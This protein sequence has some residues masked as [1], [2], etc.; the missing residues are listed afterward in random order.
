NTKNTQGAMGAGSAA[1]GAATAA[2]CSWRQ[3]DVAPSVC[4]IT[5][6]MGASPM[7]HAARGAGAR[8]EALMPP[9]D[10]TAGAATAR[11]HQT[12]RILGSVK[13]SNSSRLVLENS[14]T[15]APSSPDW[16]QCHVFDG[17]VYC[18]PGRSSIS[19]RSV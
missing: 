19:R 16:N 4:L 18:S 8:G 15:I 14:L 7:H 10:A 9:R 11:T 2:N 1:A 3:G 5:V 13:T 12:R 17:I 6:R